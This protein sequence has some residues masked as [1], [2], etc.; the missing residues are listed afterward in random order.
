MEW[1]GDAGYF[2]LSLSHY[3]IAHRSLKERERK[4]IN[5]ST[6]FIIFQK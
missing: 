1:D 6:F 3:K 5:N 2:F 4:E